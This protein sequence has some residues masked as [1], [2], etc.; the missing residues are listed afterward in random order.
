M[1]PSDGNVKTDFESVYGGP[2]LEKIYLGQDGSTLL[3]SSPRRKKVNHCAHGYQSFLI[4][5]YCGSKSLLN[6]IMGLPCSES[7][8]LSTM[9]R[10]SPFGHVPKSTSLI[11]HG[12]LQKDIRSTECALRCSCGGRTN[13][14]NWRVMCHVWVSSASQINVFTIR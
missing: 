7:E 2:A 1:G 12:K 8:S 13:S 10:S 9:A 3:L 4:H 5:T 11:C 14:L 6:K